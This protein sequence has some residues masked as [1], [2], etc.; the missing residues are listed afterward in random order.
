VKD[1]VGCK[2]D[3]FDSQ[4]P[5]AVT[6][7]RP[8]YWIREAI[9]AAT[10]WKSKCSNQSSM[11]CASQAGISRRSCPTAFLV[12]RASIERSMGEHWLN[13]VQREPNRVSGGFVPIPRGNWPTQWTQEYE[14]NGCTSVVDSPCLGQTKT[15]C[16]FGTCGER[17]AASAKM[18]PSERFAVILGGRMG[19]TCR[20][21]GIVCQ[22]VSN[23]P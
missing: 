9:E 22:S 19:E 10:Q 16:G 11:G 23:P 4:R 7:V 3:E 17:M 1:A 12:G 21:V 20:S 2:V 14:G 6:V 18:L 13:R 8:P 5:F 15:R